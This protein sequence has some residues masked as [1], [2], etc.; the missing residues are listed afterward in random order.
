VVAYLVCQ[1]LPELT[2]DERGDA[3]GRFGRASVI[4]AVVLVSIV[5]G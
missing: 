2:V 4:L 1:S 3:A 5:A